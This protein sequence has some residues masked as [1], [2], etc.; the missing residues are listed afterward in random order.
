MSST[1]ADKY[2]EVGLGQN[3]TEM[4]TGTGAGTAGP[5]VAIQCVTDT[6]FAAFTAKDSTGTYTGL[7]F[8]AHFIIRTPITAFTL[9]SGTVLA[10]KGVIN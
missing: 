6:V 7:T 10:T 2:A 9:T 8:P 5:W 4:V 1:K 3:G